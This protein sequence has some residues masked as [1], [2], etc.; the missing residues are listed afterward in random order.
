MIYKEVNISVGY[1]VIDFLVSISDRFVKVDDNEATVDG[2]F[3]L[4]SNWSGASLMAYIYKDE[5]QLFA[6]YSQCDYVA[7]PAAHLLV[8]ISD[9]FILIRQN[10]NNY[11]DRYVTMMFVTNE[12][13]H[14]AGGVTGNTNGH[15]I[16]A[17]NLTSFEDSTSGY[18]ITRLLNFTAPAGSTAYLDRAVFSN[19]GDTAYWFTELCSCSTVPFNSTVTIL[20]NNYLAIGTN[21]IVQIP[22]EDTP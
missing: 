13:K 2:K 22:E 16:Y 3:R 10:R 14:Y 8:L 7:Q 9:N 11:I 18:Q 1:N 6:G 15:N 19:N 17:L 12:D 20:G 5:D 21:T 4:R